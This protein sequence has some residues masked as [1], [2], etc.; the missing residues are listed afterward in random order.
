MSVSCH[1]RATGSFPAKIIYG[2]L[3][4]CVGE[5]A[6]SVGGRVQIDECG[7]AA[8]VAHAFHQLA[9]VGSRL[10]GQVIACVPQIV[11][12]DSLEIGGGDRGN[13][14]PVPEDGVA[15]RLS[16]RTGE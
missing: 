1:A 14:D 8:G 15:E 13:P 10:G 2:S 5:S 7:P 9:K 12:V 4:D 16:F 11:E 6:L 3:R